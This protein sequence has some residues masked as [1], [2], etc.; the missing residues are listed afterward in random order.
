MDDKVRATHKAR[1]LSAQQST[2][3]A[4]CLTA[5]HPCDLLNSCDCSFLY[6]VLSSEA[7]E[8]GEPSVH[9]CCGVLRVHPWPSTWCIHMVQC[10]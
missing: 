4:T 1:Q 2:R 8:S 5:P 10:A 6:N 9:K 3:T 7:V